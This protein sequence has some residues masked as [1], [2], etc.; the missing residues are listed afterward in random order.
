MLASQQIYSLREK[1]NILGA[2]LSHDEEK[3]TKWDKKA[4]MHARFQF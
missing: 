3:I 2:M 1:T 4:E